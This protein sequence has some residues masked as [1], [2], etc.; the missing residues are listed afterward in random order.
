M[1]ISWTTAVVRNLKTF[2]CEVGA[3]YIEREEHKHAKA[4]NI[5]HGDG[6]H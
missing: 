5:N 1:F 6:H 2:A 3:G 4:G